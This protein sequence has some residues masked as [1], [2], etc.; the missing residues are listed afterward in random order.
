MKARNSLETLNQ[1]LER[2]AMQ[3]GLTGLAN[4]C[5][6]DL[7]LKD[8]FS[9]AIVSQF[10][11]HGNLGNVDCSIA[12]FCGAASRRPSETRSD[13]NPSPNCQVVAAG[14]WPLDAIALLRRARKQLPA[15]R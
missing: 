14:S 8:A 12:I 6:F 3:D 13:A 10:E 11:F 5:Q 7:S 1:T 15:F 2:L 9:R 4:R